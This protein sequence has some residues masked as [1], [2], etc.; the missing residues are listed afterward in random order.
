M[1]ICRRRNKPSP[2]Y[3]VSDTQIS[4][5]TS[6]RLLGVQITSDLTWNDQVS[7]VTK[8]CNRLLGF[9]RTVVGN[10]NQ[11]IL[12]TLYCSLILPIVD[13]C[14][15]VWYLYLKNHINN[16]EL[17]QRRASRFILH[18]RRGDQSYNE[19][20]KQLNLID[21]RN[22]RNFLSI[23]F[24]CRCLLNS[25][26]FM[27]SNW[28]VNTRHSQNLLFKDQITAKTDCYKFTI[29]TNFPRMWAELPDRV[30]DDFNLYSMSIF[31]KH[32]KNHFTEISH[33]DMVLN[34]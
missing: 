7:N 15:P 19:R 16:I 14:S 12:F 26:S 21:L 27:F 11:N 32:L 20:L 30:R 2:V 25:S 29:A 4:V 17:I 34:K 28:S 22:R 8:K 31:K 33:A 23:S 9:L 24:A 10:Q 13:F 1:C 3:Y 18:Q 6:L 5:A